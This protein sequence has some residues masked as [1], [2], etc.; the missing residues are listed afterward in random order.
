MSLYA[1]AK[2]ICNDAPVDLIAL[3]SGQK[4]EYFPVRVLCNSNS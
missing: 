3:I 1:L 2:V 4:R